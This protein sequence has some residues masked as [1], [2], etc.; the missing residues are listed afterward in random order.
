MSFL[1][2]EY[3]GVHACQNW[4]VGNKC[5]KNMMHIPTAVKYIANIHDSDTCQVRAQINEYRL[6]NMLE[7]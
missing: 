2:V 7:K 4:R 5:A 3:C 1:V 6:E